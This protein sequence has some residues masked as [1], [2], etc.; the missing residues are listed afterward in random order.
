AAPAAARPPAATT[1]TQTTSALPNGRKGYKLTLLVSVTSEAGLADAH[2]M[3]QLAGADPVPFCR[4]K[5]VQN[6]IARALQEAFLAV[7]RVRAKPPKMA[8][9]SVATAPV[10]GAQR[11]AP[12]PIGVG[13]A[14]AGRPLH[15]SRRAALP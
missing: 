9:P 8:A 15:R 4:L 1:S 7:E 5:N 3:L 14:I 6:P 2:G 10:P 13:T 12:H 11:P